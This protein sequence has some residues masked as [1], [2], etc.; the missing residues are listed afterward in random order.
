MYRLRIQKDEAEVGLCW[1]IDNLAAQAVQGEEGDV[2]PISVE[3]A[4]AD[5]AAKRMRFVSHLKLD[6]HLRRIG[7]LDRAEGSV[8]HPATVRVQQQQ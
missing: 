3:L 4:R 2:T 6:R 1:S 5:R 7:L 8:D